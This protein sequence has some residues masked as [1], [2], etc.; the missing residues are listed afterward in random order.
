M[1]VYDS[2]LLK[3]TRLNEIVSPVYGAD[4]VNHEE[5]PTGYIYCDLATYQQVVTLNVRFEGD[6]NALTSLLLATVNHKEAIDYWASVV[7]N[8]FNMLA[9]YLGLITDK[10]E[11]ENDI[12]ELAGLLHTIGKSIDFAQF[13]AIPMAARVNVLFGKSSFLMVKEEIRDY[14]RTLRSRERE[15]TADDVIW[16]SSEEISRVLSMAKEIIENMP[17]I[18]LSTVNAPAAI[19]SEDVGEDMIDEEDDWSDYVPPTPISMD[20]GTSDNNMVTKAIETVNKSAEVEDSEVSGA[21]DLMDKLMAGV[22]NSHN[23]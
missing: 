16:V 13:V 19:E 14:K 10:M 3:V 9:P 22:T 23:L 15:E 7:P 12:E 18:S 6:V 20:W 1:L 5:M 21:V 4:D 11:L 17:G 8:P 2:R